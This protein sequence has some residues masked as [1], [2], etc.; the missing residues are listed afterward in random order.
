LAPTGL[1]QRNRENSKHPASEKYII[2]FFQEQNPAPEEKPP[3]KGNSYSAVQ[4]KLRGGSFTSSS[5]E[6]TPAYGDV[7]ISSPPPKKRCHVEFDQNP[8][9]SSRESTPTCSDV[10]ISSP[11]PKKKHACLIQR[12]KGSSP[13]S[14]SCQKGLVYPCGIP[15]P[16]PLPDEHRA[17]L[18]KTDKEK[19]CENYK[20]YKVIMEAVFNV[21][22]SFIKRKP[23]KPERDFILTS[24][25]ENP[26]DA[27]SYSL[28]KKFN[29]H[30][31]R[32]VK[33][34]RYDEG[35]V[36]EEKKEGVKGIKNPT[37][38]ENE[39]PVDLDTCT[40]SWLSTDEEK[41]DDDEK[42]GNAVPDVK[43]DEGVTLPVQTADED[44]YHDGEDIDEVNPNLT[45]KEKDDKNDDEDEASQKRHS[46]LLQKELKK[47]TS[48]S[49]S[50]LELFKKGSPNRV[51]WIHS[52]KGQTRAKE[53]I[54]VYPCYSEASFV[55]THTCTRWLS[56]AN[57]NCGP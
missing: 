14:K 40:L 17:Y 52:L 43:K 49:K 5:K 30:F 33:S 18:S 37:T 51:N 41:A 1:F 26:A 56:P 46:E 11:P 24:G 16:F 20:S 42:K 54:K 38:D 31:H 32:K 45:L 27:L 29:N 9:C 55:S 44:E 21:V 13:V 23:I 34:L 19:L 3:M 12:F 28:R 48:N 57:T 36:D 6:S 15:Y 22:F 25:E 7:D 4:P 47:K 35:K 39:D 2:S 10:D 50:I 8:T 53:V